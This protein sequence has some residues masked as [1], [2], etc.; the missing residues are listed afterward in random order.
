MPEPLNFDSVRWKMA[1]DMSPDEVDL[2]VANKDKLNDEEKEAFSELLLAADSS[3]DP[4]TVLE[5]NINKAVDDPTN[6]DDPEKPKQEATPV[7][8][9]PAETPKVPDNALT[10]ENLD[11]YMEKKKE[12]WDA[13]GKSKQD[14]LKEEEAIKFEVFGKGEVPEDWNAAINK[15]APALLDAAEKR[16]LA[17]LDKQNKEIADNQTKLRQT[18]QEIFTR[19]EKEFETL[20]TS[21]LIPDPKTQPDEY[22]KTHDAI[23]AI[24]DAHGKSNVTDAYKLW[25]IIPKEHGGGL[26]TGGKADPEAAK[27]AKIESQKE[28]ASKISSG[29]GAVGTKKGGAPNWAK[30]HNT[31]IEDLIE[32]A[33]TNYHA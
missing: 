8:P 5:D 25:S 17:R 31:S 24:G 6:Q 14:Q 28:A 7:E 11:A 15:F 32:E 22:K 13:E 18:Q 16:I 21:K 12:Q 23:I 27:R 33:Q 19:F 10:P 4:E 29:R 20:A 30:I 9:T 26:G 1:D 3:Y 2:I